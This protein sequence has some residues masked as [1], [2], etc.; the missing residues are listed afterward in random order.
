ML[1]LARSAFLRSLAPAAAP[2]PLR[3]APLAART[4][5]SAPEQGLKLQRLEGAHAGVVVFGLD[6]PHAKNALNK[7][8]V[9][10]FF[11]AMDSVRHDKWVESSMFFADATFLLWYAYICFSFVPILIIFFNK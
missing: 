8:M 10:S 7:E 3:L 4:L 1:A 2:V 6:R 5:C 11:E 9:D